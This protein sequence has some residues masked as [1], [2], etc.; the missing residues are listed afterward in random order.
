MF[1]GSEKKRKF[2]SIIKI[3]FLQILLFSF[4]FG[5][6]TIGNPNNEFKK[7]INTN[8]TDDKKVY[9]IEDEIE[10]KNR[11]MLSFYLKDY[12]NYDLNNYSN[13]DGVVNL[14]LLKHKLSKIN[15]TKNLKYEKIDSYKNLYLIKLY[16]N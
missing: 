9:A 3:S 8:I 4:L 7:F 16:E 6:G 14:F 15:E 12:I 1:L 13:N 5:M 2:F 11:R 10:S